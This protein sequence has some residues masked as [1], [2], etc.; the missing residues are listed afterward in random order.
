[1]SNNEK[2]YKALEAVG[3]KHTLAVVNLLLKNDERFCE[4][5]R[6]LRLNPITLTSRLRKLEHTGMVWRTSG[7]FNKLSVVY[8]LTAKGKKLQSVITSIEL[9]SIQF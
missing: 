5:Q 6:G 3:D 7:T 1:M 9:L 8:G 2:F 4:I